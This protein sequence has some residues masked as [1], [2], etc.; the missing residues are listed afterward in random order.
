MSQM[1]KISVTISGTVLS[2]KMDK[3]I[4]VMV[5][6]LVPHPVYGKYI[7]KSSSFLVHDE[8]NECREGDKVVVRACRSKS[9]R[10]VW[11]VDQV[12]R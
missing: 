3:T 8:K 1:K 12:Q 9:K 2:A 5:E 10:K 11:V 4:S 6:R 7:R